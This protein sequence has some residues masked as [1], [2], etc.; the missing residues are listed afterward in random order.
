M[1]VK[2]IGLVGLGVVAGMAVS[3]Q[4]SAI[5]QKAP[6]AAPLPLDELRQLADVYSLIKTDYVEPV[7]DRK[8]LSEAITGMVASLPPHSASLD[9]KAFREMRERMQGRFVGIGIE[10][11]LEDGYI[12]VVSPIEDS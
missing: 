4:F 9:K 12:T 5:A 11:A 3:L 8:L 7:E 1:K 10:V 2:S 6:V